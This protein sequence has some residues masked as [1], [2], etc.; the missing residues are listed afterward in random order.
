MPNFAAAGPSFWYS[1]WYGNT[2]FLSPAVPLKVHRHSWKFLRVCALTKIGKYP[3]KLGY[4]GLCYAIITQRLWFWK[5]CKLTFWYFCADVIPP[6]TQPEEAIV[7]PTFSKTCFVFR[8][9]NKT[10]LSCPPHPPKVP[11]SCDSKYHKLF[12][13]FIWKETA[14]FEM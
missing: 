5:Q 4:L 6:D 7:P 13:Q 9:N 11:A 10:Q 3:F 12:S 8:F 1:V 14:K 2:P